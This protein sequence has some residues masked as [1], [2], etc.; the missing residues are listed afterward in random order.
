MLVVVEPH[1]V[2]RD[3][4]LERAVVVGQVGQRVLGHEVKVDITVDARKPERR[5]LPK[6]IYEAA[7]FAAE[8]LAERPAAARLAIVRCVGLRPGSGSCSAWCSTKSPGSQPSSNIVTSRL[9]RSPRRNGTTAAP[10]PAPT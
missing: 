1:D 6:G 3:V 7:A 9:P 4:R 5:P 10:M 8:A 2:S